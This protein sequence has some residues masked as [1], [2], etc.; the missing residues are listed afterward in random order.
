MAPPRPSSNMTLPMRWI[1]HLR[2]V[3]QYMVQEEGVQEDPHQVD[4]I[5]ELD[6]LY[7]QLEKNPPIT[8]TAATTA[9]KKQT[10]SSSSS[11]FGSLFSK[12]KNQ[13]VEKTTTSTTMAPKGVYLH[14]G[15]GCGKTFCMNLFYDQVNGDWGKTKQHVHFHKFML[16][17]HQQ[18]HEAKMVEGIKGDVLPRVITKTL[19]KGRLICFDEFQVRLDEAGER[20]RATSETVE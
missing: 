5:K 11:L 8:T 15:V 10:S 17:V 18:M 14:G 19:E 2:S 9:P 4:A 3:Y 7:S 6:R 16:S 1:G 13:V 20:Q 12:V